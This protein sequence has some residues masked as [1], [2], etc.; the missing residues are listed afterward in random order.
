MPTWSCRRPAGMRCT[1]SARPTCTLSYTRSIPQSIPHGRQ[2][3]TGTSSKCMA[4][5]FSELAAPHLGKEKDLVATPLHAR[6]ARRNRSAPGAVKDWKKGEI[7]AVPGKT[8]PNLRLCERD[9]PNIYKNDDLSRAP[10]RQGRDRGQRNLLECGRR[11][12]RAQ[13]SAGNGLHRRDQPGHAGPE[14]SRESKSPRP[15]LPSRRKPT[16]ESRVKGLGSH[17]KKNRA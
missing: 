12:R 9:Y 2:R 11:I 3:P 15:S 13:A 1:T 6:H 7:E 14:S 4:E 10:D 8:M 16:A 17:G 5:K